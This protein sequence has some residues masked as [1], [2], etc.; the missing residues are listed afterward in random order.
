MRMLRAACVATLL[1]SLAHAGAADWPQWRGPKRD[2][3][4]Q[5]TGLLK[6]WPT[7]GPRRLWKIDNVGMGYSTVSI[8]GGKLFTMGDRGGRRSGAQFVLAYDLA[9]HQERWAAKVGR[10]HGGGGP[11][12]APTVDGDLL[13]TVGPHGNVTCLE[14]ATGK[15][16][17]QKNLERDFGGR[18]STM[19]KFSESPLVDGEKLLCT[20]GAARAKVVALNKRTG[21]TIWRCAVPDLGPQGRTGAAYASIVVAEPDGVRQYVQLVGKGLIGVRATD[22]K[23]LWS[24]NRIANRTANIPTAIVRDNHVFCTTSYGTGAV[25]LKLSRQGDGVKAEEVYFLSPR[26][27]E[28]I[29]GGMVLVGDY[30]YGAKG[31]KYNHEPICIEFLTGKIVWKAKPLGRL[32]CA[33]LYADGHLYLRYENGVMALVEATPKGYHLKSRWEPRLGGRGPTW[34]HP[35]IHDGKL[36]LRHGSVLA[37]YDVRER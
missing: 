11:R 36:Y 21:E 26:V 28:N 3:I 12:C 29:H 4:C 25:L 19:W 10:T 37:C 2:G 5:E 32:S 22:G 15:L 18:M 13:Y 9:T 14:T 31:H 27:F 8:A 20:P 1:C 6:Q 35:V 24:Y 33:T 34:A 16:R 7:G 30:L 17:W 23:L